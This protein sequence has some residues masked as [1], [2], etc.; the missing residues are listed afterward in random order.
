[1]QGPMAVWTV[2]ARAQCDHRRDGRLGDPGQ[3]AAPAGMGRADHPRGRIDEQQRRAIGGQNTQRQA[4]HAGHH[5]AALIPASPGCRSRVATPRNNLMTGK[6]AFA[7]RSMAAI[8]RAWL[9][10][11]S[12][13]RSAINRSS[14]IGKSRR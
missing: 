2:A 5:G 11:T 13:G 12:S 8:A 7:G 3:G 10:A 9:A 14:A 1:M 4:G 6:S